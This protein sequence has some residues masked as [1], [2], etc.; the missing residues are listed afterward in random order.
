M[1]GWDAYT[2]AM[3][4]GITDGKAAV[5]GI[6]P[7]GLWSKTSGFNVTTSEV[8]ALLGLMR[9]PNTDTAFL[10]DGIEFI[11]LFCEAGVLIRGKCGE[12]SAAAVLSA[13]SILICV[14]KTTPQAVSVLII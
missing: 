3:V 11:K 14:G 4:T 9:Q 7:V 13:K 8:N 10:I 12:Y 1:S 2:T 6:S 5:F